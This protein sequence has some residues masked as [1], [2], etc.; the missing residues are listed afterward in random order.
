MIRTLVGMQG[1]SLVLPGCQLEDQILELS[2]L[3]NVGHCCEEHLIVLG[4]TQWVAVFQGDEQVSCSL[5]MQSKLGSNCWHHTSHS[6]RSAKATNGLPNFLKVNGAQQ[7]LA[8]LQSNSPLRLWQ[9]R[10]WLI[11]GAQT[12]VVYFSSCLCMFNR[13]EMSCWTG[14]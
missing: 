10:Q 1:E 3:N 2:G 5:P 8:L 9:P 14:T 7:G 4:Y 12:L 13:K 11:L 6:W